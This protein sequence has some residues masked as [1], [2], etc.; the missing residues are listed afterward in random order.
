MQHAGSLG[1]LVW[2]SCKGELIVSAP[3]D[4]T[5]LLMKTNDGND[6]ARDQSSGLLS[7]RFARSGHSAA[8]A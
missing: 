7:L 8:G 5:G 3:S 4:V 2:D 6:R 1:T